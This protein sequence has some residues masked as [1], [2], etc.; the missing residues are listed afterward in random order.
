[1]IVHFIYILDIK[2]P[3]L[4]MDENGNSFSTN[5]QDKNYNPRIINDDPILCG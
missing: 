2:T 1:M 5:V 4:L 3:V